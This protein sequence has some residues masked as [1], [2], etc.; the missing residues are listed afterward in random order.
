MVSF[1]FS[2]NPPE[3][4]ASNL[5]VLNGFQSEQ[6]SEFIEILL[7]F[8][9]SSLDLV[10][11]VRE[12]AE[13]H[14]ANPAA[15]KNLVSSALFFFQGAIR[16][17]LTPSMVKEDLTNCGISEENAN[18]IAGLWKAYFV[19]LSRAVIGSTLMVNQLV[20][21][22]WKFGVTAANSELGKSGASF[23][24]LKLVLDKGKRQ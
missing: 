17:N 22:E 20:D 13:N 19:S 3:E 15:L 1:R 14:G 24:Q 21:M 5:Q 12:F 8:L 4:L 16:A 6:L 11:A 7:K 23:L 2:K 9:S 18:V 10:E